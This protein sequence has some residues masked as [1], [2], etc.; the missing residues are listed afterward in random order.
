MIRQCVVHEF[1]EIYAIGWLLTE[2]V[3]R[4]QSDASWPLSTKV[5]RVSSTL[6]GIGPVDLERM[7]IEKFRSEAQQFQYPL[8]DRERTADW[9]ALLQHHGG[10]TRL[11]DFTR[12]IYIALFFAIEGSTEDAAIWAINERKLVEGLRNKM[13]LEPPLRDFTQ[14]SQLIEQRHGN[15]DRTDPGIFPIIPHWMSE[16]QSLQQGLF[17][18]PENL[19]YMI[20][21]KWNPE[22]ERYLTFEDNIAVEL[23]LEVKQ[24]QNPPDP[25]EIRDLPNDGIHLEQAILKI[26]IPKDLETRKHLIGELL[27]MNVSARTL[28][29]GIEGLARS[30]NYLRE[31][32]EA[33]RAWA[34]ATTPKVFEEF[35]K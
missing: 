18:Y 16:R 20:K 23:G 1:S 8:P 17:L 21:G 28:F 10:P 27:A 24:L 35:F 6:Q 34:K 33:S 12:S 29:P 22:E 26:V 9:L 32:Y 4:G 3:F 30:Y 19:H 31:G 13:H 25:I 14:S 11:L 2:W 15:H 5:E 7:A